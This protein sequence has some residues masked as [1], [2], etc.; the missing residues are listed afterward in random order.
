MQ[1][2][3]SD[4]EPS[5]RKKLRKN[6]FSLTTLA[7]PRN[8]VFSPVMEKLL[9]LG[10]RGRVRKLSDRSGSSSFSLNLNSTKILP[11]K[12]SVAHHS[13]WQWLVCTGHLYIPN[14]MG[15]HALAAFNSSCTEVYSQHAACVDRYAC[16]HSSTFVHGLPRP[17]AVQL[18]F[19]G[20]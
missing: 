8:A 10:T 13:L 9:L 1:P 18:E 7:R 16:T 3:K 5:S 14:R 12:S 4:K 11:Q 19:R 20:R 6:G 2:T 15:C 17:T